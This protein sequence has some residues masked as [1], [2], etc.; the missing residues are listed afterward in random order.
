MKLE[1]MGPY[2]ALVEEYIKASNHYARSYRETTM[3]IEGVQLSA[4]TVQVLEYILENEEEQLP[5]ARLAERLGVTRGAFSKT[6]AQLCAQEL[7]EKRHPKES[8]REY[9][10]TL[11]GKGRRVYGAYSEA[12]YKKLFRAIF[13][14]LEQL[15]PEQLE[16]MLRIYK[17][18]NQIQEELHG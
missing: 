9:I 7:V 11:T 12:I 17:L 4:A 2:R 16:G 15:D 13:Q 8:G 14:E 18:I 10:L 5:M 6:V 1:W 3:E